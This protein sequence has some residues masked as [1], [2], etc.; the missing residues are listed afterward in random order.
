M[1]NAMAGM[2]GIGQPGMTPPPV[3]V[4]AYHVAVNGQAAGP[5]DMNAL[6]QM[7]A[8]GQ[9]VGESLVWK[10]G[11]TEWVKASSVDE[12]KGLFM[13]PVPPAE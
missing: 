12:L 6:K 7:S 9:F 3:P 4:A 2:N 5:F 13:P 11:M 1:G 8:A 10:P